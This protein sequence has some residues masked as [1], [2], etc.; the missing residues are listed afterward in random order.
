MNTCARRKN[1]QIFQNFSFR[2]IFLLCFFAAATGSLRA[3][4]SSKN[5]AFKSGETL[6]Y[7]LYFNWKFVW[8]KVGNATWNVLQSAYQGKPAFRTELTTRTSARADKYFTMR[9]KLVSYTDLDLVPL[10]YEK[11]AFEGKTRRVEK[12]WYSYPAGQCALKMFYQRAQDT[13]RQSTYQS[14]YCAFDM[15]SMMLRARSF[16]PSDYKPGHRIPF[17]MAEGK[18]AEM[19]ALVYRGKENFKMEGRTTTFRCLVFSYVEKDKKGKDKEI[20]KFY[21]TDDANHLPVRLD[22]NLRFGTAKALLTGISGTRNP[23]TSIVKK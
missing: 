17:L 18:H 9:D 13:P 4:C 22:M 8:I 16:D 7:D 12:V 3:Q 19:Q 14:K 1:R 5:T 21:I 2:L 20:V 11:D 6:Q 15:L 10:Y 23:Q